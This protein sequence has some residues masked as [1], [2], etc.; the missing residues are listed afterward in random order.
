ME[1]GGIVATSARRQPLMSSNSTF[2]T[3]TFNAAGSD[4]GSAMKPSTTMSAT[5]AA[6]CHF[7]RSSISSQPCPSTPHEST[8]WEM[9]MPWMPPMRPV[10][11]A[12]TVPEWYTDRPTL[13]PGLMPDTT[14]SNGSPK[15]PIRANIT[16]SAGG[17]VTAHDSS[18]P[19]TVRR[20][21]SGCICHSAPIAADAPEYSVSGAAITTSPWRRIARARTWSPTES[22]PSSLVRRMRTRVLRSGPLMGLVATLPPGRVEPAN[23]G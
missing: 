3:F 8:A 9:A 21:I 12:P 1:R 20:W 14:R 11:A 13:A 5:C 19:S 18:M 16:H 7:W 2:G 6:E 17:P 23:D 15:A 22:M 4:G 10:T